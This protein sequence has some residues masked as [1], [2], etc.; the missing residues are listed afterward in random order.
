M[1]DD[2]LVG[3]LEKTLVAIKKDAAA[4]EEK[5]KQALG[6]HKPCAEWTKAEW[7]RYLAESSEKRCERSFALQETAVALEAAVHRL[8]YLI[9]SVKRHG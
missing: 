9:F 6:I 2:L 3:Y 5:S 1:A 4:A 8:E 7:K